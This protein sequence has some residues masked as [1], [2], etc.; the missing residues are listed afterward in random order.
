[1]GRRFPVRRS[2]DRDMMTRDM[3]GG[4]N[5]ILPASVAMPPLPVPHV[6]MKRPLTIHK[7]RRVLAEVDCALNS[8]SPALEILGMH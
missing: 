6:E 1:M 7:L 5:F 2:G 3:I 4:V 8:F